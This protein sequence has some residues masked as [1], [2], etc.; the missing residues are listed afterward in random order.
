MVI[1]DSQEAPAGA[2]QSVASGRT[3]SSVPALALGSPLDRFA[4]SVIDYLIGLLPIAYV[5]LAP[6][7]RVIKEAAVLDDES[8]MSLTILLA[9]VAVLTL[10]FAYQ[11]V[12][13][14]LWGGT[15]GKAIMGLRVRPL[16]PAERVTLVQAMSRALCWMASWLAIGVPFVAIFSNSSRRPLHDRIAETYVISVRPGRGVFTP[17][18][19]ESA[20]A[21]AVFWAFGT[22]CVLLFTA[23]ILAM[24]RETR[25]QVQLIQNLEEKNILCREVSESQE[26]W[27]EDVESVNRLEVALTLFAAGEIDRRCLQGE[28]EALFAAEAYSP[29]LYL[30]KSFVYVDQALLSDLYLEKVCEVD[31]KS[32]DCQLT[33]VINSGSEGD[34]QAVTEHLEKLSQ[35]QPPAYISIWAVHQLLRRDQFELANQFLD[36]IPRAMSLGEFLMTARTKTLWGLGQRAEALGAE[37]VAYSVLSDES[38]LDLSSHLCYEQSAIECSGAKSLSCQTMLG[39]IKNRDEALSELKTSMAYLREWECRH[40]KQEP[41]YESLLSLSMHPDVR[42]LVSGLAKGQ[43]DQ[44][45]SLY[46]DSSLDLEFSLEVARRLVIV[47][48]SSSAVAKV[49]ALWLKGR[50]TPS[51][52]RVGEAL[53]GYYF[54]QKNYTDSL[55]IVTELGRSPHNLEKPILERAVVAAVEGG[56]M[57]RAREYL[58]VYSARHPLPFLVTSGASDRSPA[59]ESSKSAFEIAVARLQE[60]SK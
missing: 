59:S 6:F 7:Q 37:A 10:V 13:V 31:A 56:Q 16:W 20:M 46:E 57:S 58:A 28:V 15:F 41:D 42:S 60:M 35:T 51:W 38:K 50:P 8:V 34:W 53:F 24:V 21:Y 39:L 32:A 29:A 47:G 19:R 33:N 14:W 25:E 55:R 27:P 1:R 48:K 54:E 30:A 36:K 5:V 26:S 44:L 17:G 52:E 12:C 18:K 3:S 2:V 22:V 40:Q 49:E 4:A 23:Q 43:T 11:T 45:I 9:S